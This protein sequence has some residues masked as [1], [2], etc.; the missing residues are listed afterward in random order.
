MR[1]ELIHADAL[2]QA[3]RNKDANHKEFA[4]LTNKDFRIPFERTKIVGIPDSQKENF[5]ACCGFHQQI[6]S[7][8][9]E[10][11]DRFPDCCELHRRLKGQE[12]FRKSDFAGLPD[13]IL[14]TYRQTQNL[15]T[16]KINEDEWYEHITEFFEYAIESFGQLPDGF[17]GPVALHIYLGQ[18]RRGLELMKGSKERP[19]ALLKFLKSY[20]SSR[21]KANVTDLNDLVDKYKLWMKIF[22]WEI[23][24]FAP[25]K[26]HFASQLPFIAGKPTYNRY[27]GISKARVISTEKLVEFLIE[28][29]KTI[30]QTINTHVLQ[31]E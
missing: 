3:I 24:F 17:G 20:S 11:M 22:P 25:Y 8:S 16:A 29:T 13:K 6:V 5:P 23:S 9:I 4:W 7:G 28:T 2:E 19:T 26:D 21:G 12:W 30:L 15:I 14:E 10:Y 18:V 31:K 1:I 27:S